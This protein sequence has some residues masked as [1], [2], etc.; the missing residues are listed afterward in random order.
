MS[1]AIAKHRTSFALD[2]ATAERLKRLSRA[3]D[4]S[5]AEVVRRAV[6]LAEQQLVSQNL[7][8]A[9]RLERYRAGNRISRRDAEE[10]LEQVADDRAEWS[11]SDDPS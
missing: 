7:S 5:Q 2:T 3:W 10:Y 4:V 11:R 1:E 9:E 8:V 6:R